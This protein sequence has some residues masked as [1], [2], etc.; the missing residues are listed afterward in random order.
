MFS[1]NGISSGKWCLAISLRGLARE[2]SPLR[3]IRYSEAKAASFTIL[4][5]NQMS[6]NVRKL[7]LPC[8]KAAG[9]NQHALSVVFVF[10]VFAFL[11]PSRNGFG[12]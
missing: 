5:D 1:V 10:R 3:G 12:S 9:N 4:W 6:K 7:G 11:K 2:F 8:L